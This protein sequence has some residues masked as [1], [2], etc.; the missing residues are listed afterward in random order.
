MLLQKCFFQVAELRLR[1]ERKVVYLWFC[2]C[3]G[4]YVCKEPDFY[5]LRYKNVVIFTFA[6]TTRNS[7]NFTSHSAVPIEEHTY[8]LTIN[9]VSPPRIPADNYYLHFIISLSTECS[10]GI[11]KKHELQGQN[12]M[13]R[14]TSSG[15]R[16]FSTMPSMMAGSWA[17]MKALHVS[18]KPG[19][20]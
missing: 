4:Y 10:D 5:F 9:G 18:S 1:T 17:S 7:I 6:A 11:T 14:Q 3:R 13:E 8:W 16:L 20:S 15:L 12:P 2:T 19:I